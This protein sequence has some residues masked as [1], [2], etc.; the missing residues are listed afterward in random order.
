[1]K[2][3][4]IILAV[5]GCLIL[6]SCK[7]DSAPPPAPIPV[8]AVSAKAQPVTYYDRYTATTVALNQ[9]DL[10]PEIQGYITGL[11]FQEGSYVKH[12]KKLFEIDKRI[13]ENSYNTAAANLKVAEGNL[14]QAQ[15]D[16]DRY[17]FLNNN[18]AVAKQIYDHA[19][20]TLE[21]SKH[22]YQSAVEALKTAS[23]NLNY[24]TITAPF[25]GMV[26]FSQVKKGDLVSAGQ[27]VLLT[28][29]AD[30]PM[31][32]DFLII[33]KQLPWFEE[34]QNNKDKQVDS[35]FT[36]VMPDNSIYPYLGK[37]TVIDRAVNPQTGA[38]RIRVVFPNPKHA[39]RPGM[40]FVIRVHNLETTPQLI[41]PNNAVVEEMGEYFVYVLKDSVASS[42]EGDKDASRQKQGS[43]LRA[44]QTKVLL[45]A[46]IGPNIIIKGGIKEGERII[47]EGVQS[48]HNG[49]SVV[50]SDK[51]SGGSRNAAK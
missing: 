30:D 12:G 50:L 1:M 39:L 35:L 10:R 25:D 26:G 28:I 42:T 18:K 3:A 11:Y 43:S 5:A 17:E 24:S 2:N 47:V 22:A 21:N 38:I 23:T 32:V 14:K 13:Y 36:L 31:G 41:I 49:S 16:A 46:T 4:I 51:R 7:P 19:M 40:S 29:S 44:Y 48:L 33:E 9:V 20:I 15:Q 34:I 6:T 37:L 45:G 27:T 8:N